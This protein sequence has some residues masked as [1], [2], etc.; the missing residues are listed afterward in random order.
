MKPGEDPEMKHHL[1]WMMIAGIVLWCMALAVIL[2][3]YH[4][5]WPQR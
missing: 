1:K 5:H 3:K 2:L 4:G